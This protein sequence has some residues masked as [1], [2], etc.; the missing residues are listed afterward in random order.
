[1][2]F[3]ADNDI[4]NVIMAFANASLNNA[5]NLI[6]RFKS[7]VLVYMLSLGVDQGSMLLC[8]FGCSLFFR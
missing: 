5:E 8:S 1:M 7:R 2:Q 6:C 3:F 4:Y